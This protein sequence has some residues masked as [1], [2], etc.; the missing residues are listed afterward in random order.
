MDFLRKNVF[1]A[2]M[3]AIGGLILILVIVFLGPSMVE[4]ES[5]MRDIENYM[6][7]LRNAQAKGPLLANEHQVKA[8]EKLGVEFDSTFKKLLEFFDGYDR[9][10]ETWLLED[11]KPRQPLPAGREGDFLAIFNTE[12]KKLCEKLKEGGRR[13]GK[14]EEEEDIWE[15]ICAPEDAIE[16]PTEES[17]E[18]FLEMQKRFWAL[19]QISRA[20][21]LAGKPSEWRGVL[22]VEEIRFLNREGARG[23]KRLSDDI[24]GKLGKFIPILVVLHINFQDLNTFLKQLLYPTPVGEEEKETL[25]P[26][27]MRIKSLRI[28]KTAVTELIEIIPSEDA[29]RSPEPPVRIAMTVELFDFAF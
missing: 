9:N 25:R 7:S 24:P 19:N 26:L 29:P 22:R 23:D 28:D 13:F 8:L 5:L 4:R 16:F 18:D 27:A 12:K 20:I 14:I 10:L 6:S 3:I 1:W 21:L 11:L 15:S 17:E 2:S